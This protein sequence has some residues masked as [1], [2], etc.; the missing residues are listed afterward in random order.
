MHLLSLT[1]VSLLFKHKT[2][3]DQVFHDKGVYFVACR[4]YELIPLI[5]LIIL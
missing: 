4:K 2:I 3:I 5:N 1:H